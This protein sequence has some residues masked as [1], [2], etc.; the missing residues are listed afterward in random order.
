MGI[1]PFPADPIWGIPG[2]FFVLFLAM[3]LLCSGYAF[4]YLG[5]FR[6][7]AKRLDG[8]SQ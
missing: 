2:H 5:W 8:E 6:G 4:L 3:A 7:E 1:V